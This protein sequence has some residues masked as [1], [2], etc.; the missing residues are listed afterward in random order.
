MPKT[1]RNAAPDAR[2]KAVAKTR[3]KAAKAPAKPA[4]GTV[5]QLKITLDEIRPRIWRRVQTKDCTLATC[6]EVW[7]CTCCH[8]RM[9]GGIGLLR[10]LG[11]QANC[12]RCGDD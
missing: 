7:I 10:E 3:A 4:R 8:H 2:S 11:S 1:K 5:Y 6:S 12:L 9:P